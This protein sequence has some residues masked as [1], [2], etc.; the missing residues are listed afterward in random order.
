MYKRFTQ[1]TRTCSRCHIPQPKDNYSQYGMVCR[2]CKLS[3]LHKR[4]TRAG[5]YMLTSEEAEM[6]R[7]YR[8]SKNDVR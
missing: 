3:A 8:R 2:Q 6:I 5:M 4:D 1:P 7:E